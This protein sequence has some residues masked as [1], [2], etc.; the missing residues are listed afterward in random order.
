[1]A[2]PYT[3]DLSQRKVGHG[4]SSFLLQASKSLIDFYENKKEKERPNRLET[5]E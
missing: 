4:F 5:T 3:V 2:V 1:M